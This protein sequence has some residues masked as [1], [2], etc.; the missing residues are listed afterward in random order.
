[1]ELKNIK[2]NDIHFNPFRDIEKYP[3]DKNKVEDLKGSIVA[4]EYWPNLIARP[5]NG[6]YQIWYGH[7]RLA[8][9]RE[10]GYKE[11]SIIIKDKDDSGML[12][13]MAAENLHEWESKPYVLVES[14]RQARD[15]LNTELSQYDSWEEYKQAN[16]S[17]N[18]ISDPSNFEQL[19]QRGVGQTTILKFLGKPWKQWIIQESLATIESDEIDDEVMTVF[20]DD[21]DFVDL[22]EF[23]RALD[24]VNKDKTLSKDE[25]KD[26]AIKVKQ[27]KQERKKLKKKPKLKNESEEIILNKIGGEQAVFDAKM[28]E[29]EGKINAINKSA[30]DL[31]N[32]ILLLNTELDELGIDNIKSFVTLFAVHEFT[33][34]LYGIKTLSEYLGVQFKNQLS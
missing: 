11:I 25:I 13:A 9:L 27:E 34:L 18:L 22:N 33:E 23:R 31:K 7:H 19:K 26:L 28:N 21:N 12:K 10:L 16:K 2:I 29:I 15:Y 6:S 24:K 4:N 14:V 32:K 20:K 1:M 3:I 5:Y 17:I 8:A 30:G